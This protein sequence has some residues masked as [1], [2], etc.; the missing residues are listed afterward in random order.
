MDKIVLFGTGLQAE[1]FV[2]EYGNLFEIQYVLD[3]EPTKKKFLNQFEVYTPNNENC[4]KYFIIVAGDYYYSRT[5]PYL[6][7]LGK[8]EFVDFL[9]YEWEGKKMVV[10]N[11]NCY[12]SQIKKYLMQ[13]QQF[14]ENFYFY[15][16]PQIFENKNHSISVSVMQRCDV[17]LHQDIRKNNKFGYKLSDD[18]LLPF[19]KEGALNITIPNL[20]GFGLAF[21]P[22]NIPENPR[23]RSYPNTSGGLFPF[24]DIV[25]DDLCREGKTVADIVDRCRNGKRFS[26]CELEEKLNKKFEQYKLREEKWD[27]KILDYIMDWHRNVKVFYD[28]SHPANFIIRKICEDILFKLGISEKLNLEGNGLNMLETPIYPETKDALQLSYGEFNDVIRKGSSFKLTKK[29]MDMQE[30]IEEYVFWCH[31]STYNLEFQKRRI[32]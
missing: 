6:N 7:K 28:G 5:A 19:L 27:I 16:V 10:L 24:A 12:G 3:W 26:K 8:K 23:S 15:P 25:I 13:S 18:Y 21:Y 9:W 14:C 31:S 11:A 1:K 30:Y 29:D 22:Q 32:R 20:V 17:F 4:S 2:F